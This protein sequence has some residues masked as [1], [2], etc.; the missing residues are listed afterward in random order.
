MCE[1]ESYVIGI[2]KLS[3]LLDVRSE[4]FS[5]SRLKKMRGG[6]VSHYSSALFLVDLCRRGVAELYILAR[7]ERSEMNEHSVGSFCRIVNGKYAVAHSYNA[8]ISDLSS[9]FRVE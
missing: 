7:G 4:F 8:G 1:V 5:Q 3:C 6:V 9:A 2:Y